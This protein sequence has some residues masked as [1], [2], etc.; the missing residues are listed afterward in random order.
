[1]TSPAS[2]AGFFISDVIQREA[3]LIDPDDLI[4]RTPF[5]GALRY[6]EYR[7]HEPVPLSGVLAVGYSSLCCYGAAARRQ[8]NR[9]MSS[10]TCLNKPKILAGG[11]L[12]STLDAH[13]L[14]LF[15]RFASVNAFDAGTVI[16]AQG[17]DG[18]AMYVIASGRVEISLVAAGGMQILAGTL[19]PGDT[20][21]E[22]S[23][24]DGK[25]RTATARTLEPCELL[26][27]RRDDLLACLQQQPLI[28]IKLLAALA[29][30]LRMTDELIQDSLALN[31]PAKLARAVLRLAKAYGYNTAD[32]VK[33]DVPLY[34]D[35]LAY[36]LKTPKEKIAAQIDIWQDQG[37]LEVVNERLVIRDP[38][39]FAM[40]V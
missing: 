24:L 19:E 14:E 26:S 10:Q 32:G 35:E 7:P 17:S 4:P 29:S 21:G 22:I 23:L 40:Q 28:A 25:Q 16:C 13:E 2:L 30:R 20:F 6:G 37:L 27:I 36:R 3:G 12:F 33:I 8:G 11:A 5:H 9:N 1:M 18:N 31:L 34:E 15:V 38:Y 39:R